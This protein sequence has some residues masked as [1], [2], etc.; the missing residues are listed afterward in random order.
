LGLG[1]VSLRVGGVGVL[2]VKIE[3][4]HAACWL[5]LFGAGPE[6]CLV[7]VLLGEGGREDLDLGGCPLARRRWLAGRSLSR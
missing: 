5:E 2:R 4:H 1:E 6:S 7:G 3:R